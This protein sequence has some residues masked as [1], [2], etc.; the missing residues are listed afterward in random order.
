VSDD[1]KFELREDVKKPYTTPEVVRYGTI[2]ALTSGATGNK[3]DG[4]ALS[5]VSE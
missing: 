2:Q 4:I 3:S 1:V 5:A